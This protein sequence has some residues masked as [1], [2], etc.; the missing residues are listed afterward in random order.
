[1]ATESIPRATYR[2]QFTPSFGFTDAIEIVP[3]LSRLGISHIYASPILRPR[4]DSNHGYD[5]CDFAEIN[6][7]LGTIDDLRRLIG[8]VQDNDMGWVQD[9]VPNHMAYDTRNPYLMD[10]LVHGRGSRYAS[11]FDIEWNHPYENLRGRVLAPFL[12]SPYGKCLENGELK[13]V[14]DSAGL[15]IMYYEHRFPLRPESYWQVFGP[16]SGTEPSEF[17]AKGEQTAT[18]L[19]ALYTLHNLPEADDGEA[20]HVQTVMALEV[21]RNLFDGS[22]EVRN[23][24]TSMV[25]EYDVSHAGSVAT[26][27]LDTLHQE[28]FY[29][30]SYWKVA[31]EELNYRRFFT[32]GDLIGVRVEDEEVFTATHQFIFNLVDDGLIDG[33]RIDHIDGLYDPGEYLK[34][35][36]H[37]VPNCYIVVEKILDDKEELPPEWPTEGTTGYDY[38]IALNGVF[39][40]KANARKFDRIYERFL[41]ERPVFEDIVRDKKRLIVGKHMAGDIDNIAQL[42]R[43]IAG[44]DLYGRD[45]T[46]YGLR[47]AL[48]EVMTHMPV[49]R[50]YVS[51]EMI[52]ED[53]RIRIETALSQAR[54]LASQFE[55]EFDFLE[56]FLQLEFPPDI[57]D[58]F[59]ES[60]AGFVMR[61]QQFTGPLTAKGF[62]DTV[63]YVYNRLVSQNEVGGNPEHF[64]VSIDQFHA[65]NRRRDESTPHSM[66]ATSTHDTKR[67][68]D[69]RARI[70]VLSEIPDAW[71]KVLRSWRRINRKAISVVRGG[72]APSLNDEYLYYQTILGTFPLDE[73]VTDA[74]V[75]R[76]KGYMI[77]ATREAKVHTAWLKVDSAYED[78][79]LDFVERTLR[80]P[81]S[82]T[83]IPSFEQLCRRVCWHGMLNSLSQLVLK[84]VSPGVPDFYRGTELWDFSLVD[85]DNRGDVNFKHRSDILR[86]L[87]KNI[88]VPDS[89]PNE[90]LK[91]FIMWRSLEVRRENPDVFTI[92]SYAPCAARGKHA[93][94][95]IAFGRAG[96]ENSILTVVPRFTTKQVSVGEY[97]VGE[98]AWPETTLSIPA[99]YRG[100][101]TNVY[102]GKTVT[103]EP[104]MPIGSLLSTFPVGL[105][106]EAE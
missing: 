90:A 51:G 22:E 52:H 45:I 99:H 100:P 29:R 48:V 87:K 43:R 36:R 89:R 69:T 77:K 17:L 68:E 56:R 13:L 65:F 53:D 86:K 38:L 33:L 6:P 79:L 26:V 74:Y 1:M 47:R 11:F 37:R 8:I 95:L 98:D 34:R 16:P 40:D 27:R 78:A 57:D 73:N 21:I 25:R 70:N 72:R 91:M 61:F 19:G 59:R 58:D 94:N 64:G 41:G 7:Q 28:Q 66:S 42:I 63:L 50:T 88:P 49:Y 20:R 101:R 14:Y 9:I 39:C 97:P 5:V 60:W 103:F 35:L 15:A 54:E 3:Y 104:S 2:L 102:T 96:E 62:E 80:G 10:V 4:P 67:G 18:F 46:M 83:F 92:G 85:P 105:W 44:Q 23:H 76:I 12:G 93:S 71:D 84:I 82:S 32:I 30:L 81:E 75:D 55:V 31:A 106:V 24:M